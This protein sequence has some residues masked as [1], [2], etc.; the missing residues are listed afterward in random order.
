MGR[1]LITFLLCEQRVLIKPVLYLSH[2]F[3]RHREMYYERLQ[4][5]RDDGAWEAW[6]AFFLAGVTEVSDQATDTARK[7]LSLREDHRRLIAERLTRTAGK[8][9]QVL[10]HLYEHPIVSVKEVRNVTGTTYQAA[11]DLVAALE[12]CG[13]LEEITGQT[14]NRRFLYRSYYELFRDGDE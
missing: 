11:N 5:V 12:E 1:L 6:L 8:G 10:E 2:Y 3:K 9:H 7:I 4:A 13:I 14:R